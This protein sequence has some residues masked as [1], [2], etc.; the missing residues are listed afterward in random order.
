IEV[1]ETDRGGDVTYHGPGQLV[2]YPI[3]NL[4]AEP[5]QPDLHRYLRNLEE[6]LIRTVAEFGIAADRFPGYTGVWIGRDTASPEKIAAIGVKASHWITQH[7]FAL[8]VNPDLSHFDRII[9]CGIHEYGVTSLSH[10]LGRTIT[11]EEVIEPLLSAFAD[12]FGLDVVS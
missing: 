5:H 12:V 6:T 4:R 9:P 3:L 11:V 7:G 2:G 1:V 8:N 10:L